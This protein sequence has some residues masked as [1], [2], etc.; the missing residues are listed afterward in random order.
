MPRVQLLGGGGGD[1]VGVGG[2]GLCVQKHAGH[3]LGRYC[4]RNEGKK[5]YLSGPPGQRNARNFI[6]FDRVLTTVM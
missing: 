4:W 3:Q 1:G 5:L 2:G 6:C